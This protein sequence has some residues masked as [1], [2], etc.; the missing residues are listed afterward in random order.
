MAKGR[1]GGFP[2]G[3]GWVREPYAHLF[4]PGSHGT[5]YGGNPLACT[6]ALAVLD[7]LEQEQLLEQVT[8]YSADW[9]AALG[10]LVDKHPALT[11]VRGIGFHA[12]LVVGG[13][14]LPWVARLREN[15]LLTVRGGTD[16]IR[17][18]PPLNVS[19]EDLEASV[20]I[21]DF[22]FGTTSTS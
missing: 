1:C 13:D 15:G 22:V 7:V 20:E 8:T 12:A 4:T 16:A 9:H 2:I 17:L 11:A 6:A 3:A 5:T 19:R 10:K 18:M 14:P 21:I